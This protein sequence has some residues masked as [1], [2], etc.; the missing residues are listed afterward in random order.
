MKKIFFCDL[1]LLNMALTLPI[2]EGIRRRTKAEITIVLT[3]ILKKIF[4]RW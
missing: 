4:K 2:Q 3:Q 1:P